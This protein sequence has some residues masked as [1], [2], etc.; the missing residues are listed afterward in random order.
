MKFAAFFRNLN[1]G[2]GHAPSRM[3]LESAFLQAGADEA[4]SFQT[5]GTV[6]F[7]A[8]G[9][10]PAQGI[11]RTVQRSL[12]GGHGFDEPVFLRSMAY[13]HTLLARDPFEG[14][15]KAPPIYDF[16]VTFLHDGA[17]LLPPLPTRNARED[18]RVLL[19]T[20]SEALSYNH[21]V[22]KT[23]GNPNVF[24]EQQ[25]GLPATTRTWGT[26]AR[27]VRKHG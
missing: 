2:H 14:M 4:A 21:L 18:V 17:K 5:N 23:M 27:L 10:R 1:L 15:A 9:V 13:L 12:R 24:A 19:Y 22:G 25:L 3:A 16:Y 7:S 8:R 6:A 11:V 20:G 26:V